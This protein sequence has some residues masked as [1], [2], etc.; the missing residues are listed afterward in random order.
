MCFYFNTNCSDETLIHTVRWKMTVKRDVLKSSSLKTGP[1]VTLVK[2]IPNKIPLPLRHLTQVTKHSVAGN[3]KPCPQN[4]QTFFLM[5]IYRNTALYEHSQGYLFV[6]L[7]WSRLTSAEHQ[8][9]QVQSGLS[10]KI[11]LITGKCQSITWPLGFAPLSWSRT[12]VSY[13][14]CHLNTIQGSWNVF[15]S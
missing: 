10:N 11:N 12:N 7:L 8:I 1:L 4:R 14:T 6:G 15:I 2:S 3:Q 13:L 9:F 5:Q